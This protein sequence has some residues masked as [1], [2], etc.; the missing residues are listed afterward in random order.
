MIGQAIGAIGGI[1]S[2]LIGSGR[3]RREQQAAQA[4]YNKRKLEYEN[5]DTSNV[6]KNMENTMEDLTVN[7][8]AAEFQAEQ[9]QQGM[10]NIMGSMQQSAGG[11][12]I[13]ALAQSMANQQ[14]QNLQQASNS[15][16]QQEQAN[17][18]A[19]RQEAGRLNLYEKKGELISRDAQQEKTETLMGMA[20]GRLAAA[21]E[22]KQA[23]TSSIIGGVTGLAGIAA[24]PLGKVGPAGG[25]GYREEFF[26]QFK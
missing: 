9:Q 6:Y 25:K 21:N 26:G 17:N 19:E 8:Q 7:T 18:R 5:L 14:N 11:S 15:I 20:Q 13:A 24:A 16:A 23:A 10:A 3:R 22:A 2:G 4:D 1:A 12:G